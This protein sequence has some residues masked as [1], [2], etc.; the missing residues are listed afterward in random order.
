MTSENLSKPRQKHSAK[1]KPNWT[2]DIPNITSYTGYLS[3]KLNLSK[4]TKTIAALNNVGKTCAIKDK[5]K[6]ER[7]S[8]W[9]L[10]C[11]PI[12]LNTIFILFGK[13]NIVSNKT[14]IE[15]TKD[16]ETN[17][18]PVNEETKEL[19]CIAN[20]IKD[21]VNLQLKRIIKRNKN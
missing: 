6:E 15:F 19:I 7:Y 1:P 17:E 13:G 11:I 12:Y 10:K 5:I 2:I 16:N 20:L 4:S 3:E 14:I 8:N 18:I 21:K 9:L